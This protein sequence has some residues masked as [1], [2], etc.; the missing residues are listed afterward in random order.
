MNV[1]KIVV[2]GANIANKKKVTWTFHWH[3]YVWP[4]PI[5]KVTVEVINISTEFLTNDRRPG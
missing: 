5:L 4:W 1:L 3:I 2:V